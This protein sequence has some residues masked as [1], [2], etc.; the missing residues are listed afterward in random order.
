MDL[1]PVAPN[2]RWRL[3]AILENF[4]WPYLRNGWPINF[5]FDP[6]VGL[7]DTADRMDL[8]PVAPNPRWRPLMTS[9]RNKL[10]RNFG[11]KYILETKPDSGMVP[12]DSL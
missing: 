9:S 7:S 2:P 8:F 6:R 10:F 5:M 11:A 1:L 3:A 4:K 12:M